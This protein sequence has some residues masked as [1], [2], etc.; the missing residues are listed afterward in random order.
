MKWPRLN[1]AAA[2]TVAVSLPAAA[3]AQTGPE[4][5]YD[6]M[7]WDGG[8]AHWILGPLMMLLFLVAAVGIVVVLL[9]WLGGVGDAPR[10]PRRGSS[11]RGILEERYAR[12]EIDEKEF[13]ERKRT[14]EN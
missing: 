10:P 7:M 8:W 14:L 3:I 5:R 6:H 9:R 11:A 4:G 2:A 1:L 13:Q 12:G